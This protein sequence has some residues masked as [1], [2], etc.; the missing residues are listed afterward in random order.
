MSD[1][2]PAKVEEYERTDTT[3]FDGLLHQEVISDPSPKAS[4]SLKDREAH[5]HSCAGVPIPYD[6]SILL[7]VP[8]S[9]RRPIF[10]IVIRSEIL[11]QDREIRSRNRHGE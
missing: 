9:P 2:Y 11:E 4:Y 10:G 5:H 1:K 8:I 6:K 7:F 3:A